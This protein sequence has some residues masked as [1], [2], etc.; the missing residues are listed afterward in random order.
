MK[1]AISDYAKE[2]L[3]LTIKDNWQ[4]F[5]FDYIKDGKHYGRFLDFMGFRFYR[6]KTTLRKSI[7]LRATRKAKRISKKKRVTVHDLKQFTSYLG[8]ID[9]TNTY[10]M[11]QK[12]IKPYLNIQDCKRRISRYDRAKARKRKLKLTKKGSDNNAGIQESTVN[13]CS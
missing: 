10:G 5:R 11:Y 9:C 3:G 7:M 13:S 2:I 4:V 6:D 8:W 1:D 12:W